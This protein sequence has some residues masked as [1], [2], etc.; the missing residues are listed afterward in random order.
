MILK[1]RCCPPLGRDPLVG[2]YDIHGKRWSSAIRDEHDDSDNLSLRYR[3]ARDT[4]TIR[5]VS[6]NVSAPYLYVAC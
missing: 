3:D 5:R 4:G 6:D 2:F 1:R